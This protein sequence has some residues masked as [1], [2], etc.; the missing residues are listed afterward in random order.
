MR[1]YVCDLCGKVIE[2]PYKAK[3]TQFCFMV[4]SEP[5]GVFEEDTKLKFKIDL[6]KGCLEKLITVKDKEK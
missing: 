1:K 6:C 4:K 3:L 2:N 5:Y